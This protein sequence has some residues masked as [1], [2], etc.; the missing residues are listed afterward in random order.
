MRYFI[1]IFCFFLFCG[2]FGSAETDNLVSKQIIGNWEMSYSTTD[3][4]FLDSNKVPY[5]LLA[6]NLL[7]L[8]SDESFIDST[9]LYLKDSL[10]K[11]VQKTGVYTLSDNKNTNTITFYTQGIGKQFSYTCKIVNENFLSFTDSTGNQK[12]YSRKLN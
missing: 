8:K 6:K 7:F 1:V 12:N 4:N 3:S 5:T 2:I 11:V 10:V 9:K